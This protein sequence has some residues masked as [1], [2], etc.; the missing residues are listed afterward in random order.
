MNNIEIKEII[1]RLISS[2]EFWCV[3]YY[4]SSMKKA[5]H[6]GVFNINIPNYY[7]HHMPKH[8]FNIFTH[9]E[10]NN[11]LEFFEE[12]FKDAI[13]TLNKYDF[14]IGEI[15]DLVYKDAN[16]WYMTFRILKP[17]KEY[18]E[19]NKSIPLIW[20]VID[21]NLKLDDYFILDKKFIEYG[22]ICW[23]IDNNFVKITGLPQIKQYE[24]LIYDHNKYGLSR[25]EDVE[26]QRQGF[27]YDKKYY[28]YN[29]FLDTS[30][31]EQ[32]DDVPGTIKVILS[33]IKNVDFKIRVDENLAIEKNKFIST[34]TIDS[35]VFRGIKF[36]ISDIEKLVH[37]KE[38]IVHFNPETL[39]K[40][41]MIIKPDKEGAE[42]FYHI[43]IEE[44]WNCNNVKDDIVLT[45]FIHS[46]YYPARKIF[47][48][49]DF[50]VNQY[51]CETYKLKYQDNHNV[52]GVPIDKYCDTHYKVWCAEAE[53]I[54]LETW[55]KLITIT[56]DKPFREL[57]FEIIE[58]NKI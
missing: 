57:F 34:A 48:H 55:S 2:D 8:I 16:N 27:I 21:N 49:I 47:N 26:Y 29:I 11:V 6:G 39:D 17:K 5:P 7:I 41:V 56:L 46:K 51:D 43:E 50:S 52:T 45:N 10:G 38:I 9:I 14:N 1:K 32:I 53:E 20:K 35:Q 3:N 36:D 13:K 15:A 24:K 58:K 23:I 33:E 30:I 12:I 44:L 18:E 40:L 25:L 31:L 28:L 42:L 4:M 19:L 37:T 54:A 22:F